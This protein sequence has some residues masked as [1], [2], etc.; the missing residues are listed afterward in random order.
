MFRLIY[1]NHKADREIK[2]KMFTDNIPERIKSSYDD[3]IITIIIIR[4]PEM[5]SPFAR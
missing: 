1:R 5:Q 3:D 2:N 4:D